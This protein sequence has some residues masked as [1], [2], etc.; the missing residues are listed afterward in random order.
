MKCKY[1]FPIKGRLLRLSTGFN[2][3]VGSR[4]YEFKEKV[5]SQFELSVIVSNYPETAL[6]SIIQNKSGV[7]KASI[8]VPSDPCWD[9][10]VSDIRAIEGALCFWGIDEIDIDYCETEWIPET[11]DEKNKVQLF[12]FSRKRDD[13]PPKDL[14]FSSIDMFVRSI[15]AL[16]DLKGFEVP[17]NFFRRGRQ[18]VYEERYIEAIYDLYF[19]IEYM[20]AEGKFKKHDVIQNLLKSKILIEAI[21]IVQGKVDSQILSN[22]NLLNKFKDKYHGKS[23]EEVVK[24]LVDLRGFLHHYNAKRKDMW[25]PGMQMDF[26]V[27]ALI[28]L[29]ICHHILSSATLSVLFQKKNI[30]EFIQTE[31]KTTDGRR[32]K[33]NPIQPID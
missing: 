2:F 13:S 8:N 12:S 22:P 29:Q 1:T 31:V 4:A 20:Y 19:A 32:F 21:E 3:A 7:I 26:K 17:L 9:E 16:P 33:W 14:P 28:L 10:L 6:P 11:K 24:H 30:Q 5:P 18:D 27:D 25:H 15:L 23:K